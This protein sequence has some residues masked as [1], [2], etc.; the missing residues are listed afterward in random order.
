MPFLSLT[1]TGHPGRDE[2]ALLLHQTETVAVS[3]SSPLLPST[4]NLPPRLGPHTLQAGV[5][6][7]VKSW[8]VNDDWQIIKPRASLLNCSCQK[9]LIEKE[10]EKH[11]IPANRERLDY[12]ISPP[13][14]F[15]SFTLIIFRS[16]SRFVRRQ[17]KATAALEQ[18]TPGCCSNSPKVGVAC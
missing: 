7:R 18:S 12:I 8:Q 5:C 1:T 10:K 6:V 11:T 13:L 3:K 2:G 16:S 15:I 9:G 17:I 4:C 14:F